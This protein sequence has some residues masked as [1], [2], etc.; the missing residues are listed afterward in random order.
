MVNEFGPTVVLTQTFPKGASADD[1]KV[2]EA[3]P[4]GVTSA[5]VVPANIASTCWVGAAVV[6]PCLR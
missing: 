2:G 1:D 5:H 4:V 3:A 6:D